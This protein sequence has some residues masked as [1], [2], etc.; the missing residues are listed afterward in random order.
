[1][2][3]TWFYSNAHQPTARAQRSGICCPSWT[4]KSNSTP[5]WNSK[6]QAQFQSTICRQGD[7]TRKASHFK[8]VSSL[9]LSD[10]QR[11]GLV[12]DSV[13]MPGLIQP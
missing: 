2:S 4:Q 1:M 6:P 12:Q 11:L 10:I 3:A 13:V 9:Y 5:K 7:V 8:K